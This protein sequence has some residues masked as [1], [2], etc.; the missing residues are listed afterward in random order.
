MEK[1]SSRIPKLT[2][3]FR[4]NVKTNGTISEGNSPRGMGNTGDPRSV[5]PIG[6]IRSA[7]GSNS[8]SP[9]LSRSKSLRVPRSTYHSLKSH[10]NSSLSERN[11]E[12]DSLTSRSGSA[13]LEQKNSLASR[14]SSAILEQNQDHDSV[15]SRYEGVT[16]RPRSKTIGPRTRPLTIRNS[17]SVSPSTM[18]E[19]ED[20]V[21]GDSGSVD[22]AEVG[23]R[24]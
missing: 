6:G 10:S 1:A 14:S 22:S 18:N 3:G 15:E 4:K 13:S 7:P 5:T 24:G 12:Q 16:F 9:N 2:F 23:G 19:V 20:E 8:T 17:R 11:Q 21:N